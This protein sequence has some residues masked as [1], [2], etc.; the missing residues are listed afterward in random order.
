MS[1]NSALAYFLRDTDCLERLALYYSSFLFLLHAAGG[2]A[3]VNS[4]VEDLLDCY[5]P[6]AASAFRER[7][8]VTGLRLPASLDFEEIDHPDVVV[9]VSF[10]PRSVSSL[11]IVRDRVEAPGFQA[12]LRSVDPDRLLEPWVLLAFLKGQ[13][14]AM[15]RTISL[16]GGYRRGRRVLRLAYEGSG[17]EPPSDEELAAKAPFGDGRD[18]LSATTRARIILS[19]LADAAPQSRLV[20]FGSLGLDT[21]SE[22][23]A[24]PQ[25]ASILKV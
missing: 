23:G 8:V 21:S 5:P 15:S 17:V 19:W 20:F 6:E 22:G 25:L 18:G 13:S 1:Y 14:R 4:M 2:K 7:G 16:I 3:P 9:P 10:G 12:W 24:G 11:E